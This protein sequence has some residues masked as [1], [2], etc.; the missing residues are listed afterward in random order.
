MASVLFVTSSAAPASAGRTPH[1]VL[2]MRA[3]RK[4]LF[5]GHSIRGLAGQ[6]CLPFQRQLQFLAFAA[7]AMLAWP[8]AEAQ[9]WA[10]KMF[11]VTNHNFGTVAKGSKTEYRF[12]FRNLY[13]EDLHVVGVRTSCGCTTP[14]ITKK[15]IKT[16][17][18]SEVVAT[19]NTR[20]FLGQHGATLTVTFDRPFQAEV[21]LRVTGNIRGDVTF[22]PPFI[23]LGNVDLGKGVERTVRVTHAGS[24]PWEIQD[25]RSVNSDFV[26]TLSAPMHTG[27]Q[28]SY[29]LT[30]KLKPE[31][32]AGYVKGQLLLVTNDPRAAQIPMDVEGRVVAE[33]T[34]SPQLLALGTVPPGGTVTKN[35]VIRANRPFKVTGVECGP[36]GCITCP[37]KDSPAPVH[38]LPVT[39]QAGDALGK[40]ERELRITTDLGDGTVPAVTVQVTV[41]GEPVASDP[42]GSVDRQADVRAS[43]S[44]AA[45]ASSPVTL[46]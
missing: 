6:F 11:Q 42:S 46:P 39:F 28:S 45:A 3:V 40:I 37:V 31:A 34:V 29:D 17:E 21:Q 20:T 33:V 25:V 23:D 14:S 5:R 26:V 27:S 13:K 36:D 8:Q 4:V 19:F 12:T 2:P 41:E 16:H 24:S 9:E 43:V 10:Q 38:I 1:G 15:D 35:V 32:A 7:A 44:Q 30:M 18:T 22:D